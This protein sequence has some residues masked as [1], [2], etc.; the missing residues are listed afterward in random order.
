MRE[1]ERERERENDR[2]FDP[3]SWHTRGT[4]A[5]NPFP[6]LPCRE[7][8]PRLREKPMSCYA[9]VFRFFRAL[10]ANAPTR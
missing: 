7:S 5:E 4:R 2:D 3:K 10:E 6:L 8:G 1:R 9:R